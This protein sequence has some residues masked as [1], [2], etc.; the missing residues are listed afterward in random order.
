MFFF[1]FGFFCTPEMGVRSISDTADKRNVSASKSSA[2]RTPIHRTRSIP[3]I[4][5]AIFMTS[6]PPLLTELYMPMRSPSTISRTMERYVGELKAYT[7]ASRAFAAMTTSA[8]RG[9]ATKKL[10]ARHM[11]AERTSV[12][13]RIFFRLP[14]SAFAPPIR[15]NTICMTVSELW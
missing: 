13:M 12:T 2:P 15:L 11:A 10:T 3:A 7:T 14:L 1:S 6:P 5:P 4:G 8:M 9:E